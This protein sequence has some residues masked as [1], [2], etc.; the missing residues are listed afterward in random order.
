ME[1]WKGKVA[2]VTGASAGIGAQ[3]V[4]DLAK[5]GVI[6]IGL[7]RRTDRVKALAADN[8]SISGQ[9][10]A[11]EC[12]VGSI[13]SIVKAFKWIEEKFKVIHII[14]NNA[15]RSINAETLD[16]GV[17][18]EQMKTTIDVNLT[19]LVVCT[20]EAFRLMEKHEELGYIININSVLGHV[21][22]EPRF[23]GANVYSASK[24][25]VT[26]HTEAVR[27]NLAHKGNTRIRVTVS[28]FDFIVMD[29]S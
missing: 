1:Y 6:V 17:S 29:S 22:Y 14:I 28:T 27:L 16:L 19:G 12:D 9:I 13:D 21:S 4:V 8:P 23:A 15:G 5:A 18:H 24:F 10:H 11:Y 25:G 2:V 26:S 20:R 7:A 3:V